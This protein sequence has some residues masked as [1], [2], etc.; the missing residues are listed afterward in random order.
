MP[1]K[2]I[3]Q[4]I[5]YHTHTQTYH[6]DDKLAEDLTKQGVAWHGKMHA[7]TDNGINF[8]IYSEA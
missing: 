1:H 5:R 4:H 3:K 6:F 8:T 2:T 7:R